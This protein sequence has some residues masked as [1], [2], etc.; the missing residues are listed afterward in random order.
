MLDAARKA[1]EFVTGCERKDLTEDGQLSFALRALIQIIGEAAKK[2]T[3]ETQSQAPHIQWTA[4]AGMRNRVI[5]GYFDVNLEIVWTT[6]TQD[7]PS[8][9]TALETLLESEDQA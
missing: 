5:H 8:L 2:V 4:I 3:V 9:V 7:L 1:R 6:V